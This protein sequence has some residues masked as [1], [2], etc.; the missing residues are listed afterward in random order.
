MVTSSLVAGEPL[1]LQLPPVLQL[2]LRPVGV[3][4]RNVLSGMVLSYRCIGSDVRAGALIASTLRLW[5]W[6]SREWRAALRTVVGGEAQ[7][8][9]VLHKHGLAAAGPVEHDRGH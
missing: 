7:E 3:V 4:V 6:N 8:F 2:Y 5:R 1:G 9:H